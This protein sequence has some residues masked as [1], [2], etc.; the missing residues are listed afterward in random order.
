MFDDEDALV[1]IDMS[2]YREQ[3]TVSRL[4][5]APPGYVGY[6]EGGQLTE[7]RAPP[8]RIAWCCSTRSRRRTRTCG[9]RCCRSWTMAA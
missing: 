3:H 6:D 4:F 8:S 9:T 7:A 5:G 2:E 1:R